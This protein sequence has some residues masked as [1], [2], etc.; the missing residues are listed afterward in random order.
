MRLNH[1]FCSFFLLLSFCCYAQN[2]NLNL[3][4]YD[5]FFPDWKEVNNKS[6]KY[7]F[8]NV[9]ENWENP[10]KKIKLAVANISSLKKSNENIV[11]IS[12]GPGGWSIGAIKKWLNHPLREKANIILV[13]LRGTGFSQPSLCPDIGQKML[14]VFSQDI[15]GNKELNSI[16]D[17]SKE[18]K[19]DLE[20]RK[21]DPT[22]YNSFNIAQDIHALKIVLKI[23]TWHVYGIS[24]GTHI[25]Q[26]YS[27]TYTGDVKSLILD[28]P[29][30]DISEY[31]SKNTSNYVHSLNLLFKESKSKFPDLEKKYHSVIDKLNKKGFS[32]NVNK[33]IIPEGHF[34]YNAD[35]FKIIIQQSLYNKQLIEV[36]P[37]IINAF[38]KE[39]ENV[40]SDLVEA[41]SDSLKRDFGTYYCVTCSDVYN[42]QSIS[43]FDENSK[44]YNKNGELLFYRSDLFVCQNWGLAKNPTKDDDS[45]QNNSIYKTLIFAGKYDPITPLSNGEQLAKQLKNSYLVKMPYG[46]GT[47]FSKEGTQMLARFISGSDLEAEKKAPEVQFVDSNIFY[48]KGIS[49][50]AK[51]FNKPDWLFLSALIIALLMIISSVFIFINKCK[52]ANNRRLSSFI[53]FNSL[54]AIVLFSYLSWGIVQTSNQNIYILLFGLIKKFEFVLY[55]TYLY[56]G[57]T[58]VSFVWVL[59]KRNTIKNIELIYGLIFSYVLLIIYLGYWGII[60]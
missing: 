44:H 59:I 22:Q 51:S 52:A 31:Y 33:K 37:L 57:S 6:I 8:F 54:L 26:L 19:E 16:I 48:N 29:I 35:D 42:N 4:P 39:D 49:K 53:L 2:I 56:I 47:S 55:I 45:Q 50:L 25:A 21:I 32:V 1:F 58:I 17:I 5:T 12:G 34:I 7:Y 60:L 30:S 36:I 24:Y 23:N 18:C 3:E 15:Y 14:N 27:K 38:D 40:L 20:R 46:H 11:F 9:P 13:D 41:F 28:S 43:L 10:K